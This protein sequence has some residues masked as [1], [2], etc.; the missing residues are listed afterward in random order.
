MNEESVKRCI[1][2]NNDRLLNEMKDLVV[3]SISD[4][5]RSSQEIADQHLEQIKKIKRNPLPTFKRKSNEDQYKSNKAVLETIE[6]AQSSLNA[7]DLT[8][9]KE[10]LDQDVFSSVFWSSTLPD[11]PVVKRLQENLKFTILSSR[12]DGTVSGYL[13]SF[14]KWKSFATNVLQ[15]SSS[16]PVS[17]S[18]FALFLQHVL[19]SSS[20]VSSINSVFYALKWVHNLANVPSPTDHPAII[21]LRD[22]AIRIASRPTE[23]RKEPLEVS[24]LQK[25]ASFT[26][27]NDLIQVRILL[28]FVLSFSGFLRSSEVRMLRCKNIT[29]YDNHVTLCIESSK[30]DQLREGQNIP[31]AESGSS[32][33]PYSLFQIRWSYRRRQFWHLR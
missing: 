14:I 24:H 21:H 9:V 32:L 33:C 17:A 8:K 28:M 19:E 22:G 11:D 4:L 10:S 30:T 26:N 16:F 3:S 20:S 27:F 2:E 1:R 25:L 13:R 31:I 15:L 23:H 6:D 12:A 18:N 7:G 29:F 5:K